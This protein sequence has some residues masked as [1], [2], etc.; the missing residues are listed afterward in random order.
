MKTEKNILLAFLLNLIFSVFEFIGGIITGSVAILSDS[1]H[2]IGD[3]TSIGISYFLERKSKRK[4]DEKY[5]YGYGRY[6][7]IG[8][9]ITT[10]ILIFG[11]VTVIYNAIKRII[12]PTD[13]NYNGMLILAGIGVAI[14]L[15]AELLTRNGDSL[16]QRAVN[17]HMLE[18]TLGW[19][20]VLICALIMKFTDLK[21]IDPIISICIS[22]F[23]FIN[24]LINLKEAT[25]LFLEKAPHGVDVFEIKEQ[26]CKVDGVLDVHH[27]HIWS[28]DGQSNYATMH[29]V[30]CK[31]MAEI[32]NSVRCIL[33][34]LGICHATLELETENEHCDSLKCHTEHACLNGHHHGHGH[35]H[36]HNH[37]HGH[38]RHHN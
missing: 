26:I 33:K 35:S 9:A 5:T 15:S 17:L 34:E 3:A 24:A 14:N 19:I 21:I 20:A 30:T 10:L 18:D 7:V 29:I 23:I 27:I 8:G 6:S 36:G 1:I 38:N 4:P 28:I 31:E 22:V 13:I 25:E 16:N 32:K 2:D 12:E 11:S 37:G